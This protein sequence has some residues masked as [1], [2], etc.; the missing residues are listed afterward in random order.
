M[1][2]SWV[3]PFTPER[4]IFEKLCVG[5]AALRALTRV[6]PEFNLSLSED[7]LKGA[8]GSVNAG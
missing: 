8:I 4:L 5:V 6:C 2:S 1:E 3:E 7:L